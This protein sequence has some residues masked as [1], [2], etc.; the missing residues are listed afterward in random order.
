MCDNP[1]LLVAD[2]KTTVPLTWLN[3][4]QIDEGA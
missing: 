1:K 4:Q 3:D 2:G